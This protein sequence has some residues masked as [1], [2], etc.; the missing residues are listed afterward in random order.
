MAG[1]LRPRWRDERLKAAIARARIG[2]VR[3]AKTEA[4]TPAEAPQG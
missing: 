4:P 2:V 3:S 1:T